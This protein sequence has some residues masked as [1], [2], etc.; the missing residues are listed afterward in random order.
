MKKCEW[1]NFI[2]QQNCFRNL[3]GYKMGNVLHY[4]IR[5]SRYALIVII[6]KVL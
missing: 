1:F 2:L 6:K 5:E 3:R 4:D